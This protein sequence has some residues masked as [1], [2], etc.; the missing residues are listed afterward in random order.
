MKTVFLWAPLMAVTLFTSTTNA[1][2]A[3]AC[4]DCIV[5]LTPQGVMG[6]HLHKPGE[7]MLSYS[8]MRMEMEG[9]RNGTATLS[10]EEVIAFPNPFAPP[11]NLRV[12]P[13]EMTM[14]MHMIGGMAGITDKLT[15]MVMVNYLD[16]SMDHITF[17]M[18]GTRIGNFTTKSEG[19][20]D[21]KVGGIYSLTKDGANSLNAKLN[22]SLPTGS[23]KEE[24]DVLTPMGTRPTLRMP[25]AMQLGSGTYDLEPGLTY[26]HY[27]DTWSHGAAY[28]S[29]LHL[30]R[31]SQGYS[32][33][34]WHKI[35]AWTG[36]QINPTLGV[37]ASLSARHESRIDGRDDQI[38]APVQTANPDN[39]GG[40]KIHF[41]LQGG[42]KFYEQNTIKA[43]VT[44]PL[45]Q[46]L[47]GPQMEDDYSFSL[48]WQNS[49]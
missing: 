20:G 31:N 28:K 24:D 30:G 12:V 47:N 33:G 21:T 35:S 23:I 37:S 17:N 3:L 41:G 48:R 25:Y 38:S 42:W 15:G 1:Q 7:Y 39:Y 49:F 19:F 13:T 40:E 14:D 18:A 10:P 9:N 4:T 29:R 32:R 6:D 46:N 44:I 45:Y 2:D 27:T 36:Y 16:N 26:V 8:F 5:N 43:G 34:D 22:L 11:A